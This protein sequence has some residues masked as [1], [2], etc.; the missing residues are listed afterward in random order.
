MPLDI[1]KDYSLTIPSMLELA[2]IVIML[3]IHEFLEGG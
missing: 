2:T 3:N 1:E